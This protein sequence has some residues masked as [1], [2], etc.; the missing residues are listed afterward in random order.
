MW[1]SLSRGKHS[2]GQ[3]ASVPP[4]PTAFCLH[5]QGGRRGQ[6]HQFRH[7]TLSLEGVDTL[8]LPVLTL[9][10]HITSPH[11]DANRRKGSTTRAKLTRV[12]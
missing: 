4:M 1:E 12:C 7:V 2:K 9:Q 11:N 6:P 8:N 10:F 3:P 5:K